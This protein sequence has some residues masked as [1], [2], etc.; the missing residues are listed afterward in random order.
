VRG[1]EKKAKFN[2][3]MS[4]EWNILQALKEVMKANGV[5]TTLNA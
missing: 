4:K 1:T 5:P 2:H 3:T